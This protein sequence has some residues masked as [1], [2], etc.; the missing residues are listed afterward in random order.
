MRRGEDGVKVKNGQKRDASALIF[1]GTI[2]LIFLNGPFIKTSVY[3]SSKSNLL[4]IN[5]ETGNQAV[6]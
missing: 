6:V 1:G 3:E 4:N 5:I 2:A